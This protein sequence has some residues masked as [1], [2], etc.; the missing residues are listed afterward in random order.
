MDELNASDKHQR[1]TEAEAKKKNQLY[2]TTGRSHLQRYVPWGISLH[3]LQIDGWAG[4]G[5]RSEAGPHWALRNKS[6]D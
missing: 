5:Q 4:N 2:G 6:R 3:L 1:V